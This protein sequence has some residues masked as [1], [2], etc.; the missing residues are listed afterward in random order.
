MHAEC[1]AMGASGGWNRACC[2]APPISHLR[3]PPT[4]SLPRRFSSWR[5]EKKKSGATPHATSPISGSLTPTQ[6]R[7]AYGIDQVMFGNVVGDGSGQTIAIIDAYDD[8]NAFA[9]LQAFDAAYNL[10]DPPSFTKVAQDGS[11]NYPPTDP[12]SPST[13]HST[14]EWEESLDIQWAKAC[15]RTGSEPRAGRSQ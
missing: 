6:I 3:I 13:S 1:F 12:S 10:P 9:D 15:D 14:W 5:A 11:T 7:H 4:N 2:L 8:P